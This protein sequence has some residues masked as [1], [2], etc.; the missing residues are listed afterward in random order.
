MAG[1]G[2]PLLVTG[3]GGVGALAFLCFFLT[4]GFF[5]V[6]CVRLLPACAV[7][8][9]RRVGFWLLRWPDPLEPGFGEL[10]LVVVVSDEA[11][12]RE[13]DDDFGLLVVEVDVEVEVEVELV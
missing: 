11:E 13:P 9:A 7:P 1:V 6:G 2:T 8:G 5:A 10:L 4:V 3:G 12:D